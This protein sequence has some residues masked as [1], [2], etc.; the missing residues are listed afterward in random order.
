MKILK[1]LFQNTRDWLIASAHVD[2]S[3]PWLLSIWI[4]FPFVY[5][6]GW[7]LVEIVLYLL[8][9]MYFAFSIE[10]VREINL[11][12]CVVKEDDVKKVE[13]FCFRGLILCFVLI[14]IKLFI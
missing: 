4:T 9:F 10:L 14:T 13:R 12:G 11:D 7:F 5:D 1:N 6:F 8:F 2:G 3:S